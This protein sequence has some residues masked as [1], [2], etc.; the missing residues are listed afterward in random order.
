[1]NLKLGWLLVGNPLSHCSISCVCI[2]YW[3]D[4]FGVESFLGVLDCYHSTGVPTWLQE[5]ASPRSISQFCDSQLRLPLLILGYLPYPRSLSHP[6][7]A[8]SPLHHPGQLQ[9]TIHS[10]GHLTI[11][12]VTLHTWSWTPT[13]PLSILFS[14]QFPPSIGVL[15]LFYSTF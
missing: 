12:P 8:P 3:Q 14:T 13:I 4:K 7:D 1:M 11:F 10:H 5:V 9:V 15:R 2:S 6:G